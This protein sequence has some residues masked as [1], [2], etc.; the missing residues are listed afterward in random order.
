[1]TE[2]LKFDFADFEDYFGG[3]E[4]GFGNAGQEFT[5]LPL[6]TRDRVRSDLV[7]ECGGGG[8]FSLDVQITIASGQK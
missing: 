2:T 1:M 5:S 6:D 4:K 7:A 8:P 3:V